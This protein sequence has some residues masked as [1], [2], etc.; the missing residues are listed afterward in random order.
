MTWLS[1]AKKYFTC[2][3]KSR[4]RSLVSLESLRIE[5]KTWPR[6]K[7]RSFYLSVTLCNSTGNSL[8]RSGCVMK[9]I[10]CDLVEL[11]RILLTLANAVHMFGMQRSARNDGAIKVF[12]LCT[13]YI[14]KKYDLQSSLPYLVQIQLWYHL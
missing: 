11:K 5:H 8:T 3:Q 12:R 7:I 6:C 10:H 2:E 4:R 14:R 1:R 13:Q 9:L